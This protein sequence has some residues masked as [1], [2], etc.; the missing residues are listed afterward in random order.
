MT[1]LRR[2]EVVDGVGH[3]QHAQTV[4]LNPDQAW[5]GA[6]AALQQLREMSEET[7]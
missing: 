7:Y 2:L 5:S 3:V 6:F 4:L 1:E